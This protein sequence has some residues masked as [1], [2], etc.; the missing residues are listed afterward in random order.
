MLLS[1]EKLKVLGVWASISQ[2]QRSQIQRRYWIN[3]LEKNGNVSRMTENETK[4]LNCLISNKANYFHR[5]NPRP[6]IFT[7]DI[8]QTWE[9]ERTPT[10]NFQKTE[11]EWNISLWS[12]DILVISSLSYGS[13]SICCL[14]SR[15][16]GFPSYFIIT[17]S[18]LIL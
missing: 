7:S 3:S 10:L 15:Y 5:W 16:L 17:D 6:R 12:S 1:F 18:D 9:E 11:K 4:I 13:F 8:C 2:W 14:I